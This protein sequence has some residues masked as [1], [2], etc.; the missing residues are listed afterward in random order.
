[1]VAVAYR[2]QGLFMSVALFISSMI[3]MQADSL[4]S[5]PTASALEINSIARK[6]R[7]F[8]PK[9]EFD[10]PPS[11][12][13]V[14]GR[15]FVVEVQPRG[16]GKKPAACFGYPMW[17]Y[18]AA[19][20]TLYVSTG[21][22]ELLLNTFLSKQG[23]VTKKPVADIWLEKIQYFASGCE[24]ADMPRYTASNAYGAVFTIDPTVQT[25][26]AIADALPEGSKW[27]DNFEIQVS[28]EEARS[29]VPN[30]LVRFTGELSDWKP[31]VSV[32]CGSKRN[33]PTADSPY[34]RRM[35]LCLFD[36]RIDR[37]DLLDVRSGKVIKT[38][39]RPQ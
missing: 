5:A 27:P 33:G 13:S 8:T 32:A 34:D 15:Q 39:T 6:V 29:L 3:G 30:L 12:A 23:R 35:N 9:D 38:F 2:L 31:G 20:G 36:G 21:A 1:M 18:G 19:T 37:M 7:S 24:R 11:Q 14:A 4:P 22:D 28:G 17:S 25:V 26:T 10:A 16:S